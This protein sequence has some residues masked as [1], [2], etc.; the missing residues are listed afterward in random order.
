MR[1]DKKRMD[2]TCPLNFQVL[3]NSKKTTLYISSA[4]LTEKDWDKE[5]EIVTKNYNEWR[6]LNVFLLK[7]KSR[8]E[9]FIVDRSIQELEINGEIIKSFYAGKSLKDKDFYFYFDEFFE[10][11]KVDISE[12]TQYHYTLLVKQ[13]KE[14]KK[15]LTLGEMDDDFMENL[16]HY[17]KTKKNLGASGLGMRRK[18]LMTVFRYFLRKRYVITN[19]L[20]D[21]EKPIEKTRDEFITK[22]GIRSITNL[23]LN[24]GYRTNGLNLTRDLFLF[25]CFTGLRYGDVVKIN[26]DNIKGKFLEVMM[27][28]TKRKVKVPLLKEALVILKKYDY[29]KN[30]KTIF[31]YRSNEAINMDLKQIAKMA[32]IDKRVSFHTARHTFG[33]LLAQDGVQP[34][35]IMKL[36]GHSKIDMTTRYVNSNDTMLEDAMKNVSFTN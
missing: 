25:S 22:N 11:K 4:K 5:K 29:K 36:I 6:R 18:N 17:W 31:P 34:F 26:R 27:S 19:P 10:K 8:L 20:L 28:K 14:Y 24:F 9:N 30:R 32:R 2:G 33:S 13:I 35:Y 3:V 7:E 21:I 23:D 1:Y 15:N 16:F 12:G